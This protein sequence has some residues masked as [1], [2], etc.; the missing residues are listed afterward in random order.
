MNH[1]SALPIG[2]TSE[3][4]QYIAINVSPFAYGWFVANSS[5]WMNPIEAADTRE[6]NDAEIDALSAQFVSALGLPITSPARQET[7][8]GEAASNPTLF[9][10]NAEEIA[11]ANVGVLVVRH[12]ALV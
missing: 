8:S 2:Q 4:T 5:L 7:L 11:E 12:S 9:E 6:M 3:R 1:P 10:Q